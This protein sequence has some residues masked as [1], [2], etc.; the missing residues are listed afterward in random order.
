MARFRLWRD[1]SSMPCVSIALVR[2]SLRPIM[3]IGAAVHTAVSQRLPPLLDRLAIKYFRACFLFDNHGLF[4]GDKKADAVRMATIH[5][6]CVPASRL[7]R[8]ARRSRLEHRQQHQEHRKQQQQ[9]RQ[10]RQHQQEQQQQE[11]QPQ[12]AEQ[13]GAVSKRKTSLGVGLPCQPQLER[14]R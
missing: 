7:R 6:A 5:A 11:Q 3:S 9:P 4:L 8:Y 10:Q 12:E 13:P 1:Q 14:Y 2:V